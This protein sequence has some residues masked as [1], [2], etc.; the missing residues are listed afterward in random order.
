MSK[1]SEQYLGYLDKEMTIMGIL[2]A[3]C[4]GVPSVILERLTSAKDNELASIWACGEFYFWAASFLMLCSATLFYKQR[5]LLAFYYGRIALGKPPDTD[6]G[7]EFKTWTDRADSWT[8]WIPYNAGIWV[9]AA[10][11]AE[12]VFGLASYKCSSIQQHASCYACLI[13]LILP[14][15][16]VAMV[17][18]HID[19]PIEFK[20]NPWIEGVDRIW[21][22]KS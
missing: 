21:K 7:P 3:F 20:G 2:S 9:G 14:I 13:V 8:T 12:Y 11:T 19:R 15:W 4:L 10:A 5:S 22:R 17:K 6:C 1:E 16:L 18:V